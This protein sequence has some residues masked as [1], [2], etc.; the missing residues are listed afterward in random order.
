MTETCYE[1]L[2]TVLLRKPSDGHVG[3][4]TCSE[5]LLTG[6]LRN[7]DNCHLRN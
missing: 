6:S 7:T 1:H 3:T 5:H 4:E 2:L